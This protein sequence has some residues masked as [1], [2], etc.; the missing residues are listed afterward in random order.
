MNENKLL[1]CP[2]CGSEAESYA[3][4]DRVYQEST[5]FLDALFVADCTVCNANIELESSEE[6]ARKAWNTRATNKTIDTLVAALE[7]TLENLRM[8][9]EWDKHDKKPVLNISNGV[10]NQIHE[11]LEVAK[12]E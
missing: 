5:E 1:P 4:T 9:A 7:A 6:E 2:F 10:L 8:R 11:A 12:G 3:R